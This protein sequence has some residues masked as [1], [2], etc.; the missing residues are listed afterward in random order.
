MNERILYR[1][2]TNISEF[3]RDIINNNLTEYSKKVI[4]DFK[5]NI[6]YHKENFL[7]EKFA[8]SINSS[9]QYTPE[10]AE[11]CQP[12]ASTSYT[13]FECLI[14]CY[15]INPKG[16]TP[17]LHM[18]LNDFEYKL[19]NNNIDNLSEYHI[20]SFG[21]LYAF[22]IGNYKKRELSIT[23]FNNSN[24]ILESL[25]FK[26]LTNAVILEYKF[27]SSEK[28]KFLCDL[29]EL[30]K[31]IKKSNSQYYKE[32]IKNL[33]DDI[34][35]YIKNKTF[36]TELDYKYSNIKF[37]ETKLS[38]GTLFAAYYAAESIK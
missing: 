21:F 28:H 4:L 7:F 26:I 22:N 25:I 24:S 27:S 16:V 2:A 13:A 33:Y 20:F 5:N 36:D 15:S 37:S 17:F 12:R 34:F 11:I 19:K 10:I 35:Y 30:K 38:L 1:P 14:K 8:E 6:N 29:K 23:C 9:P 31:K 18:T 3:V 32:H